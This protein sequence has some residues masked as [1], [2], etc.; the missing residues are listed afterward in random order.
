MVRGVRVALGRQGRFM[1]FHVL[2]CGQLAFHDV[3]H[4]GMIERLHRELVELKR[5]RRKR[6]IGSF[7]R[8]F[9]NGQQ[10]GKQGADLP[11][12]DGHVH[13]FSSR[14]SRPMVVRSSAARVKS[15]VTNNHFRNSQQKHQLAAPP[16]G[17]Y[18]LPLN[19]IG[20]PEQNHPLFCFLPTD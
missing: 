4:L 20:F 14:E 8:K 2:A 7:D 13:R 17:Q 1:H 19:C 9:E 16:E 18:R 10:S 6:V 11:S 5:T 15:R 12:R 3:P